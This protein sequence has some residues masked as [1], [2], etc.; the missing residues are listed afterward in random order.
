[1]KAILNIPV[2]IRIRYRLVKRIM[3]SLLMKAILI[4]QS[5]PYLSNTIY[6]CMYSCYTIY[7]TTHAIIHTTI[8]Y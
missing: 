2:A 4:I 5:N 8:V 1:M 7:Q 6:Y 3:K